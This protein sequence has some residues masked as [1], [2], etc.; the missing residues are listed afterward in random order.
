MASDPVAVGAQTYINDLPDY[1]KPYYQMLLNGASALAFDPQFVQE[2]LP[3]NTYT[4]A[5]APGASTPGGL[6]GLMGHPD[7]SSGI[8]M[9]PQFPTY[10]N[11]SPAF[12]QPRIG[13]P[14]SRPGDARS[15]V[16]PTYSNGTPVFM[17]PSAA[18]QSDS[19]IVPPSR[20]GVMG[21]MGYSIDPTLG[22]TTTVGSGTS[23]VTVPGAANYNPGTPSQVTMPTPVPML[24]NGQGQVGQGPGS[25][26]TVSGFGTGRVG[27]ISNP[28][29]GG[30]GMGG[31]NTDY[32]KGPVYGNTSGGSSAAAIAQGIVGAINSNVDPTSKV[33]RDSLGVPQIKDAS[34]IP[35]ITALY[36]ELAAKGQTTLQMATN[37][38]L[39]NLV[40]KATGMK[41]GNDQFLGPYAQN[42]YTVYSAGGILGLAEGGFA[43]AF[44]T[45]TSNPY[46]NGYPSYFIQPQQVANPDPSTGG[47]GGTGGGGT[48]N[49]GSPDPTNSTAP[50]GEGGNSPV[51]NPAPPAGTIQGSYPFAPYNP[52]PGQRVLDTTGMFGFDPASGSPYGL[53]MPTQFAQNQTVFGFMNPNGTF[54][55]APLGTAT[56]YINQTYQ[57]ALAGQG[58]AANQYSQLAA[59]PLTSGYQAQDFTVDPFQSYQVQA[60]GTVR[61]DLSGFSAS[62]TPQVGSYNAVAYGVNPGAWTDQGVSQA[63]MDP[64]TQQVTEQQQKLINQNFDEQQ[65]AAHAQ[66]AQAGAYGGTRQA[67]QDALSN[68]YRQQQLD[69][70]AAQNLNNAYNLGT[71][72][73]NADRGAVMQAG[74][75]GLQADLANQQAAQQIALANQQALLGSRNTGASLDLQAQLANQQAGLG[76][77]EFNANLANQTQNQQTSAMLAAAGLTNQSQLSADQQRQAAFINQQN[78]LNA[79]L[80]AQNPFLGYM[81]SQGP[82][83]GNMV[84]LQQQMDLQRLQQIGQVGS[85]QDALRQQML[86][87]GYQN[88]V[89]QQNWPYQLSN[90]YSGILRGVPTAVNSEGF[91]YQAQNPAAMFGLGLAGL[92][93]TGGYGGYGTP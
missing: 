47:G 55:N 8:Y 86:D 14:G 93:A 50:P 4:P 75:Y 26:S 61:P 5:G 27:P 85:Q 79:A 22:G 17:A 78:A 24:P 66:A 84:N 1:V 34:V 20:S 46:A 65:A 38:D 41:V 36:N 44:D 56:D 80:A 57:N 15:P 88:Y 82:N 3:G 59:N 52:Y 90:Y 71:Q 60:P 43:N 33:A 2:Q 35:Q 7:Q 11:G 70:V 40:A 9:P 21:T 73:F 39:A 13:S 92:G 53:S 51:E 69:L 29:A 16:T 30:A 42:Q 45:T 49:P 28:G 83:L 62:N 58:A 89:N 10:A 23:G 18:I 77:G 74:Q 64:Y 72:Q 54:A 67:V 32:T 12:P 63:Y 48:Y 91:Q 76:A 25:P 6:G 19:G 87:L 37:Q 68:R 81:S 31:G